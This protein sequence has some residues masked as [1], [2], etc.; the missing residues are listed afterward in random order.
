MWHAAIQLYGIL[1]GC[2]ELTSWMLDI[3]RRRAMSDNNADL[4]SWGFVMV[5]SG[6]ILCSALYVTW[7][8]L[9]WKGTTICKS[10]L[11]GDDE[12]LLLAQ[13]P[14]EERELDYVLVD[15]PSVAPSP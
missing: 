4:P 14:N 6:G 7:V 10:L 3:P 1:L 11:H 12:A 2:F 5:V 9:V 15:A 8:Y 13:H